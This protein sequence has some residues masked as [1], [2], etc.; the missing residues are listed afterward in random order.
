MQINLRG[1]PPTE[2][3]KWMMK[4]QASNCVCAA[5]AVVRWK[6]KLM[7]AQPKWNIR[8]NWP[9]R[10]IS[11]TDPP[12]RR[13]AGYLRPNKWNNLQ[14]I[15]GQLERREHAVRAK[16]SPLHE[17][18]G[19]QRRT[20]V[21]PKQTQSA[22]QR[23]H[24]FARHSYISEWLQKRLSVGGCVCVCSRISHARGDPTQ[25]Y[26]MRMLWDCWQQCAHS[27]DIFI[28]FESRWTGKK[29]QV[30]GGFDDGTTWHPRRSWICIWRAKM[31]TYRDLVACFNAYCASPATTTCH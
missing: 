31:H 26:F 12:T 20:K 17:N 21:K 30:N 5:A 28:L 24:F 14:L 3:G 16:R 29:I 2:W 6:L 11:Q 18:A 1:G 10:A 22:I 27:F 7:V 19:V 13:L 25:R 8:W 4:I 23:L 15:N 9:V